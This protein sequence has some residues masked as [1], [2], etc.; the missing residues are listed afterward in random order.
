MTDADLDVAGARRL[1]LACAGLLE[2]ARI[3]LRSSGGRTSAHRLIDHFG[4]LQLDTVSIAGARSHSIVLMSRLPRLEPSAGEALLVPGA[5]LF[6]Y[7]AHEASW[8]PIDLYP[9]FEF[10]RR[11]FRRHPWWG[12]VVSEHPRVA[13]DLLSRIERDGPLRSLDMEGRGSRGWWDLKIARRVAAALWS[14]G[15][16]AIRERKGF[17]RTFDLTERVIPEKWRKARVSEADAVESLILIALR[18]HGWATTGTLARTFRFSERAKVDAA[19]SRLLEKKAIVRS[20]LTLQGRRISGWA[21]PADLEL[22]DRLR[23]VDPR[24]DRPVLLSPFDPLLWERERVRQLFGFDQILEIFKPASKRIYGYYCLPILAGERL[25]GRVDLKADRDRDALHVLS[26]RFESKRPPARDRSAAQ[27]AL[28][29][30]AGALGL[31][32]LGAA[33]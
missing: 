22:A 30:F 5:P 31:D 33:R 29:R 13:K 14:S 19:L 2:P 3:G 1:A 7:W 23:R 26:L 17:Q 12:D 8:I 27:I 15:E 20:V 21:R 4:Y 6:E 11:A 28:E 18:G 24:E 25:I 9:V 10:R 32:L 16:L